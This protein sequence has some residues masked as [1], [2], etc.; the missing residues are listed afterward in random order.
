MA[1]KRKKDLE[2]D[3]QETDQPLTKKIQTEKQ[4]EKQ[5]KTGERLTNCKRIE[6]KVI[7]GQ[8]T[9]D[10][11]LY[12]IDKENI[13]NDHKEKIKTEASTLKK[14]LEKQKIKTKSWELYRECKK[15][16]EENEKNWE[17]RKFEREIEQKRKERLLIAESKKEKIKETVRKRQLEENIENKLKQLPRQ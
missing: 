8:T 5:Q 16:L 15:F 12:N 4:T 2:K 7:Q 6:D 9:A 10:F 1:P 14:N 13:L 3:E 11:E 17:K